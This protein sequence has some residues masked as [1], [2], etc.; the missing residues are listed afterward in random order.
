M[1]ANERDCE[2]ECLRGIRMRVRGGFNLDG[3]GA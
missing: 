3:V 2:G 1:Q